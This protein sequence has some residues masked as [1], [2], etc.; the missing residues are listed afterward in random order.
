MLGDQENQL[1]FHRLIIF[2]CKIQI[3]YEIKSPLV[4]ISNYHICGL[5]LIEGYSVFAWIKFNYRGGF[6]PKSIQEIK[7]FGWN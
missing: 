1:N 7:N 2:A 6:G 4:I 3:Y 5:L